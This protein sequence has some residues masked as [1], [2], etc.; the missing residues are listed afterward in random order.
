MIIEYAIP[1]VSEFL[2]TVPAQWCISMGMLLL[3]AA[4]V[5]L[6]FSFIRHGFNWSL[7]IFQSGFARGCSD[8]IHISPK[9][10]W[11]ITRLTI[12]ESI[13]R[14]VVVVCIVFL[15]ILMFAGW[16]L[17]PN[18]EDP[19]KLFHSFVLS[20]SS[21]LVML[22]ALFLSAFSLPTDFK[23]KT[24]YTV[25]T[26][27]VRSSEMVLG[28]ILGISLITSV[29]LVF[30]AVFSYEFVSLKLNH[31]HLLTERADLT[32]LTVMPGENA[33][34]DR[35]I[36]YRGE[37]RLSNGHKHLVEIY[38]D[39]KTYNVTPVNGHTHDLEIEK[40][41][42]GGTRYTVGTARGALQARTPI[43]G[44]LSFRNK[45][46]MDTKDGI[47]VGNEWMYR[48]Y[49][50]GGTRGTTN[51]EAA[52]FTFS[53]L[54]PDMFPAT[55]L[56]DGTVVPGRIPIE[57]TLG[58][59][60]TYKADIEQRV[61]AALSIRNPKTGLRVEALTFSTEEFIIKA[62]SI[63]LELAGTPQ[64]TQR[65]SRPSDNEPVAETPGAAEAAAYRNDPAIMDK[66]YYD[67]FE[68]FVVDG[69]VE[70][71]LQCVDRQQYIGVAQADLY[72]RGEDGSVPLNFA[73]GF[74]GIWQQMLI[75]IAFGVLFSTFLSGP[76][77]L[78]S[79]IGVMIAGF[80]KVFLMEIAANTKLGGGPAES[81]YRL[82]T[83]QNMVVDL[84]AGIA[85]SFIKQMDV[86]Y[87]WF[88]S[89]IGQAIPPLG[90]FY[91]YHEALVSG[92]NISGQWMIVH[93]METIAY[94]IPLFIVGYLILA[95]REVAK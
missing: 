84:P 70:I 56:E 42:E 95:S 60:R 13:R 65:K 39:G 40:L 18:S 88:V 68:D 71:W 2:R 21:Y 24:V 37:T 87:S 14:R 12:K 57:M 67:F 74:F 15:V 20:T 76:V 81:F 52:I 22:L 6:L 47:N 33:D 51:E 79:T 11:A 92:F 45:E 44:K 26:K 49:I 64:I 94:V 23:T 32:E 89:L 80:W 55:R 35:R 91:I 25:V 61:T 75:M 59:F 63:P 17:D 43:Y 83:Q 53:G 82:V 62:V 41:P 86:V 54:T 48:S 78:I 31:A 3:A 90:D 77:A 34:G 58:V 19:A 50:G 93:S 10:T 29:I 38:G 27:P 9:R 16:F 36:A 73:K 5:G 46:S 1:T 66:G 85:T 7:K 69:Q 4:V 8:F 72:I 28:R 30:M